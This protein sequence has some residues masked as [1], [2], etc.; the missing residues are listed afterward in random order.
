MS[1]RKAPLKK[2]SMLSSLT[3]ESIRQMSFSNAY[4]K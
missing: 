1:R 3:K 4:L 2:R